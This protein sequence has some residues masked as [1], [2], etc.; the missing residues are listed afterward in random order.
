R[1]GAQHG[2]KSMGR[3]L[4]LESHI[5]QRLAQRVAMQMRI[6][7]LPDAREHILPA[8]VLLHLPEHNDRLTRQAH[9]M[10]D[11]GFHFAGRHEPLSPLPPSWAMTACISGPTPCTL[12]TAGICPPR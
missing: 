4:P 1:H 12:V 9:D 5:T 7:P 6:A 10:L 3:M 2:P 11:S 8:S